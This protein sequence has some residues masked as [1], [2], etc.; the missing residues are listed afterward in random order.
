MATRQG[1][2]PLPERV[3]SSY[4]KLLTAATELNSASDRF[5]KL[6]AEI[7]ATLKPLNIGITSWVKMGPGWSSE[8]HS[9][10]DQVGYHKVNGKWCVA[11]S[12]VEENFDG[13]EDDW[14]VWAFSD[15]PRRLRLKAI[16]YLPNLLDELAKQAV[17]ET[18]NVAQKTN[19]LEQLVFALKDGGQQ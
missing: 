7:D 8:N 4:Q 13:R 6:V 5:S 14:E 15:G 10:Y 17:G 9:G 18:R 12:S 11:L 1:S 3:R 2:E 19:D 16:D